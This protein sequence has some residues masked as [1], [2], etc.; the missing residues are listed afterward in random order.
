[1]SGS[2]ETM[3]EL[4]APDGLGLEPKLQSL[5]WAW[6]CSQDRSDVGHSVH[7]EWTL[8]GMYQ[9]CTQCAEASRDPQPSQR[10]VVWW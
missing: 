3:S 6:S 9:S 1:M 5:W 8:T 10:C 7:E 4:V 2:L